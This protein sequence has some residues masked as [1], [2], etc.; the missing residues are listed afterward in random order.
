MRKQKTRIPVLTTD[1]MSLG[2]AMSNIVIMGI[3]DLISIIKK[4]I[5]KTKT[6][7]GIKG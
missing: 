3:S 1:P 2:S 5:I 7:K 4:L 6:N